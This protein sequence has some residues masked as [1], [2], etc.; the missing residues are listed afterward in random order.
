M[1]KDEDLTGAADALRALREAKGVSQEDLADEAE[2]HR[3]Q[4]GAYERAERKIYFTTVIRIL[5]ALGV[6]WAEFCDEMEKRVPIHPRRTRR[7]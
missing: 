2:L 4:V 3:T 6:T 7:R 5:R 1:P